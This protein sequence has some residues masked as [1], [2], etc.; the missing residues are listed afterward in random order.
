MNK[1]LLFIVSAAF[2]FAAGEGYAQRDAG[3]V[4]GP[5]AEQISGRIPGQNPGQI[6]EN[7]EPLRTLSLSEA[8]EMTL[9]SNGRMQA[10][11]YEQKAAVQ[12]RKAA[13]GLR[14]P[15]L[16]VTGAY[17]YMGED[18]AFDLNNIRD[19]G[20]AMFNGLAGYMDAV[21]LPLPPELTGAAGNIFGSDWKLTLQERD[22]AMVGAT[23]KMPIFLGGKINAA[24]RAARLKE[25]TT[26]EA[27]EQTRAEL[28]TELVERYYGLLLAIHAVKV[29]RQVVEAVLNHLTD[30]VA[31]E[32]NGMIAR[33]ERL[34][35]E[36]KMAEAE[37]DLADAEL[38]AATIRSALCNTIGDRQFYMP[39]STM[40]VM[41][42]MAP[43]SYFVE[44]AIENN[45]QLRQV[46]LTRDLAQ[47]QTKALRA[48]FMPQVAAVGG[49]KFYTYQLSKNIPD[50]AVGATVS[51][52]IFDGLAREHKY[53]AAR[54]TVRRVES[55]RQK[56]QDDITTLI[57]SLYNELASYSDRMESIEASL[58]FAAEY[59][60]VTQAGFR[61]GVTTASD[62][63]DAELN[64]ASTRIEKLRNAYNYD[65]ALA[66]LLQAAGISEN[67]VDYAYSS[68]A[69]QVVVESN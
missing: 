20:S 43:V 12:E 55:L 38:Q 5:N 32:Q 54:N 2:I 50:W 33:S 60:R 24:N 34:Y 8:L 3:Q 51:I 7:N 45:P 63:I 9:G 69:V 19:G 41:S 49:Y 21:G 11:Q 17:V 14:L 28:T 18:I 37:R 26:V 61:E 67:F 56:A 68:S 30:A 10:A 39:V 25:R 42:S 47:E 4:I 65:L 44:S 15:Q 52:N 53:G 64:L 58:R 59:V 48:E 62:V 22:F 1:L 27:G 13:F 66:R 57:E 40:F 29:R 23:V 35:V 31:L 6:S 36:V 16:G 46:A